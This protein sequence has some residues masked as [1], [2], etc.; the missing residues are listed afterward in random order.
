MNVIQF[1]LDELLTLQVMYNPLKK[2]L[3]YL[4]AR[5]KS[6]SDSLSN[7]EQHVNTHDGKIDGLQGKIDATNTN[8]SLLQDIGKKHQEQLQDC[9]PLN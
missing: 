8:L 4:L 3:E 5:D 6:I 9:I 2:V 7:I 1:D